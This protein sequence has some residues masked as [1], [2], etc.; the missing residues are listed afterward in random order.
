M[1][2]CKTSV[3]IP[4]YNHGDYIGDAVD[5]VLEQTWQDIEILVVNDGSD[6][7]YTVSTL[8]DLNQPKTRVLHHER[9]MGLPAAR[10]TGIS[11]AEGKYICCLDADDKLHPT[12]L[13]KALLVLEANHGVDIIYSWTQVFGEEDRV[14]YNPEFDP[15]KLI[16][17]NIIFTAAVFQRRDWERVG[18]YREA[19]T[20]GY[21]DW[22]FWIRMARYGL[23]GYRIPE[24]LLYVR[25][26]GRSFIHRAMDQHQELVADIQR[27]NPGVFKDTSWIK[28]VKESYQDIFPSFP[29]GNFDD[30]DHFLSTQDPKFHIIMRDE[31]GVGENIS[32]VME[33]IEEGAGESIIVSL[34]PLKE[35]F[36]DRLYDQTPYVYVLPH[37]LPQKLWNTYLKLLIDRNTKVKS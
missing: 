21:E 10:N 30:P 16:L 9:N 34:V 36:L 2:S 22:E 23:R 6:D 25:R 32:L 35:R 8:K 24:K 27:Y 37:Y 17:R 13:E 1:G 5:S 11:Q 29:F 18:G 3:I 12:Y 15:A 14:W 7:E 19:M 28:D 31:K 4:C 20:K 33:D 26:V